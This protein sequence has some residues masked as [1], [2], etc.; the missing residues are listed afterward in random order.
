MWAEKYGAHDS[1]SGLDGARGDTLYHAFWNGQ[2]W[3]QP[4]DIMVKEPGALSVG[5][6][7]AAVGD[8]GQIYLIWSSE[9][10]LYFSHVPALNA[11]DAAS[12]QPAQSILEGLGI[13][14]PFLVI[15]PDGTLHVIFAKVREQL[16]GNVVYI[17]SADQ[18]ISWS[19]PQTLSE[20]GAADA[21]V[22]AEPRMVVD[23]R[24]WLHAVWVERSPPNWVGH[25]LYYSRS[26]DG[27]QT[28]TSPVLLA[29]AQPGEEWAE[30]PSLAATADGNLHLVWICEEVNR[31]YRTSEDGGRSWSAAERILGD[32]VGRGGWDAMV[33][34]HEGNLHFLA[35][36]RYPE[37]IYYA[38]RP[39]QGEWQSVQVVEP[40]GFWEGHYFQ[41]ALS[42]GN[43]LHAVWQKSAQEGDV[44][45]LRI[46]TIASPLR[47][48]TFPTVASLLESTSD[49]PPQTVVETAVSTPI[50]QTSKP[51]TIMTDG[52]GPESQSSSPLQMLLWAVLPSAILVM[53]VVV[54]RLKR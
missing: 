28:W 47:P 8:D 27:G 48:S 38:F 23:D 2:T 31:C 6:P 49:Q 37:G 46:S 13:D 40:P 42:E 22:S 54:V 39:T 52:I 24:G 43:Q 32:L 26:E 12:W 33:A 30:T 10:A 29:E 19:L 5:Y 35:L 45:Y 21:N 51:S 17:S 53:L 50:E 36:L 25:R 16:A 1:G 7:S 15:G 20:I 4:L 11:H 41:L 44:V 18:G 34:D 14:R 9:N 3:S